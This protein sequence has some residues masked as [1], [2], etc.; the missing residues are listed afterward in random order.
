MEPR[1]APA[2][3]AEDLR[4]GAAGFRDFADQVILR[5]G[6]HGSDPNYTIGTHVSFIFLG[7]N[8][9]LSFFMVLGFMKVTNYPE[10]V[11]S[12]FLGRNNPPKQGSI[13][14]QQKGSASSNIPWVGIC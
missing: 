2:R 13:S 7:Y 4:P 1:T 10:P 6:V 12:L 9:K 3:A 5:S 14:N 11:L 8:L